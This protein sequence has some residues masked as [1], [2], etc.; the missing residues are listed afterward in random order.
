MRPH[1]RLAPALVFTAGFVSLVLTACQTNGPG[2]AAGASS[3][4]AP[5][6]HD[7]FADIGPLDEATAACDDFNTHVNKIAEEKLQIPPSEVAIGAFNTLSNKVRDNLHDILE[8]AA[9]DAKPSNAQGLS[10]RDK[11]GIL[12]R[13]AL[14]E[15]TIEKRGFDPIKPELAKI[16]AITDT[17]ALLKYVVQTAGEGR[18]P[19]LGFGVG[20]DPKHTDVQ[21]VNAAAGGTGLPTKDFYTDPRYASQREAYHTLIEGTLKLIGVPEDQVKT[22]ADQVLDIESKIA[23]AELSPVE[24]RDPNATYKIV[25]LADADKATPHV[26]WEDVFAAAK[27]AAP[28]SLNLAPE[29]LFTTVDTLL[30]AIPVGQWKAYLAFHL[31][32]EASPALSKPFVDNVFEYTKA[33]SGQKEQKPRWQRAVGSTDKSMGDAL[34]R[35]YVEKYV[36]P[37]TKS[38]AT[39]LIKNILEA[40]KA[41]I[42]KVEWMTSETKQKALDKW[43]KIGLR[44]AYPDTW[45]NWDGLALSDGKYYENLQ[46]A[47]N[48][49]RAWELSHLGKPTNKE[50]WITDPQ[51]VNAFYNP[52][53]NTINFPAA[54]LQAPFYDPDRDLAANYGAIG[55]VI[56]H[57]TTHAFD[58]QGRQYDGDGNLTDWWTAQDAAQFKQRTQ[59]LVD[60]FNA[61]HPFPD[62]PDVHVNG[63]LTLGENIADLGGLLSSSDALQKLI[64]QKADVMRPH[65]GVTP[66]QL[67]FLSFATIWREKI[68]ERTQIRLLASDPHSPNQYRVNGT[69]AN[70][71]AFA[72]AFS[73]KPGAPEAH[74]GESL[75]SIW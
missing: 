21:I 38:K 2:I 5:S 73:C 48:F 69:V 25:S 71:P 75:V 26:Q 35:L 43:S 61:Y 15:A 51:V 44:V 72:A 24:E 50:E 8:S 49:N 7:A 10:D 66:Q 17:A 22:Q 39:E 31:A 1:S 58:D 41:R 20:A 6:W 45:R 67:F 68:E 40:V 32:Y 37:E 27:I 70:V 56:G 3:S 65:A 16:A 74:S 36:S 63:E 19:V 11:L 33:T 30:S 59:K 42:E 29:R 60:Q 52:E 53:Y 28:Q 62:Q 4:A 54:I 9:K 47:K 64:D 12:Y 57:E 14:D 46:S 23:V 18:S 13:S 55:A 34:G